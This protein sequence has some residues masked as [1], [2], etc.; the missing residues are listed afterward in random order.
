MGTDGIQIGRVS[1][2]DHT[3]HHADRIRAVMRQS[4]AYLAPAA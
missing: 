1:E 3:R 4:G 2:R